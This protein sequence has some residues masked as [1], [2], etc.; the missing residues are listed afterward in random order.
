MHWA[1]HVQTAAVVTAWRKD[2]DRYNLNSRADLVASAWTVG[3]V[4]SL[5]RSVSYDCRIF[6]RVDGIPVSFST[7]MSMTGRIMRIILMEM[8]DN[9]RMSMMIMRM[10]FIA[11]PTVANRVKPAPLEKKLSTWPMH[12]PVR[13]RTMTLRHRRRWR[14]KW[15]RRGMDCTYWACAMAMSWAMRSGVIER[16]RRELIPQTKQ[17]N[18]A[19]WP[20]MYYMLTVA[21]T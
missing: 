5:R 7:G 20:V 8:M 16:A 21:S 14:R 1:R 10:Q 9:M 6:F 17:P 2:C 15:V 4:K 12:R 3:A 11:A 18:V 13:I 19:Q